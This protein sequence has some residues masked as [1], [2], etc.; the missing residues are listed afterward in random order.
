[1]YDLQ[2]RTVEREVNDVFKMLIGKTPS[3]QVEILDE[4]L[5][6]FHGK[7]V[8]HNRNVKE[9][10]NTIGESENTFFQMEIRKKRN[11]NVHWAIAYDDAFNTLHQIKES[12]N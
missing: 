5:N 1:M 8:M 12:Q 2:R 3:Q 10:D 7:T 9:L 6:Y 11:T 4:Y